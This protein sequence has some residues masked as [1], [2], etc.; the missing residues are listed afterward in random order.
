MNKHKVKN[1]KKI[2]PGLYSLGDPRKVGVLTEREARRISRGSLF[3]KNLLLDINKLN[4][5]RV[6]KQ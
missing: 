1:G 3:L 4:N 6:K 5:K 2:G